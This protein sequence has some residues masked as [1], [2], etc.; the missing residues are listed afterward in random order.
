MPRARRAGI[1]HLPD[2]RQPASGVSPGMHDFFKGLLLVALAGAS[3][4]S[5]GVK[6]GDE[7]AG[8][9]GEAGAGDDNGSCKPGDQDGIVG[10]T[11]TVLLNVSDTSFGVGGVTSGSTQRNIAVQN[12]SNVKLT[13]TNIG[14]KTHDFKVACIA[15]SLLAGCPTLSCFPAAANVD[16]ILPGKSATVVFQTPAVEGAYQFI[17]DE[18]GDTST[19]A[20]GK[21]T[22]LVGEFVLM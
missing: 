4:C 15:T 14:T 1:R 2:T 17:S 8:A 18:P 12:L 5:G 22:G 16:A 20:D 6:D 13:I 19:D 21:L 9:A 11:N 10:G 7:T 3:A